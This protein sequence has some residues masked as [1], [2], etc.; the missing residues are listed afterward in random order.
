MSAMDFPA[1]PTIGQTFTNAVTSVTY[2]WDGEAWTVGAV[3]EFNFTTLGNILLQIRILLQDT[4]ATSGGYRY[5]TDSIIIAF[6]QGLLELFRLRPDV[7]LELGF[8]VPVFTLSDLGELVGI[9]T[10]YIPPLIYYTVGLVQARDDEQ[11]Q[12][13][14]AAAYLK[15]FSQSVLQVA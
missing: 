9:E 1:N 14:R 8:T 3:G 4:D 13:A 5:T 15:T 12:D 6:D 10:Q 2:V 11:N 7:F